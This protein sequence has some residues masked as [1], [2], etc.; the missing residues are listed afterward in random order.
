MLNKEDV[1]T[2]EQMEWA[3]T[4]FENNIKDRVKKLYSEIEYYTQRMYVTTMH[5]SLFT[6]IMAKKHV[7]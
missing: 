2:K 1:L 7:E 3:R 4:F 5:E 6:K